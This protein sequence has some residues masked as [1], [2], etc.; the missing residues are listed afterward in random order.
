M[1]GGELVNQSAQTVNDT[2]PCE[3]DYGLQPLFKLVLVF[4]DDI[5]Q[6][7]QIEFKLWGVIRNAWTHELKQAKHSFLVCFAAHNST[8]LLAS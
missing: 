7:A 5:V 2:T 8:S 1:L 6:V 3:L 4:G